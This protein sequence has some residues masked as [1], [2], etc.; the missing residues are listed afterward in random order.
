MD[1]DAIC[2]ELFHGH[3]AQFLVRPVHRV[4]GLESHDLLPAVLRY[5]VADFHRGAEGIRE[6]GLEIREVQHL[7][8]AG[9]QG[10]AQL[11]E[12]GHTGVLGIKRA[13]NLLRHEIVLLL[14]DRLHG[15]DVHDRQHRVPL[16][17]GVAQGD[18]AAG[19]DAGVV[20]PVDNGHGEEQA[21]DGVHLLGNT[22]GIGQ[23]HVA[24]Q[25]VEIP[26][27]E[28]H[29]IG[30]RGGIQQQRGQRLGLGQQGVALLGVVDKKRVEFI[31]TVGLD[32][33]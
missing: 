13:E 31:G 30:R 10:I 32:H 7:D 22:E 8:R 27:S 18:P 5:L 16:D 24:G 23:V 1:Q 12:S 20:G 15:V 21:I 6:V 29:R 17:I 4:A 33:C 2:L 3:S 14:A 11:A 28:H 25:G 9:Q 26:A 19:L